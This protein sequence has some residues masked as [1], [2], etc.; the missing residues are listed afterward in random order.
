M[1]NFDILRTIPKYSTRKFDRLSLL[2]RPKYSW[3]LWLKS[4]D[5]WPR[6]LFHPCRKGKRER[7]KGSSACHR[8][9]QQRGSML[10]QHGVFSHLY[11]KFGQI[12][13]TWKVRKLQGCSVKNV[14]FK[15]HKEGRDCRNEKDN[16]YAAKSR[17][18][19]ST[20]TSWKVVEYKEKTE[21][22]IVREMA[23][24]KR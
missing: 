6:M 1:Q 16:L 5:G 4:L 22:T 3:I 18:L 20:V 15:I 14:D 12:D 11:L 21:P 10:K 7:G 8:S 9:Q 17:T 24:Q 2:A 23:S 19:S 13:Q